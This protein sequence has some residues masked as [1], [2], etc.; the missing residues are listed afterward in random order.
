MHVMKRELGLL[1]VFDAVAQTGSVTAAANQ[2]SMSQPALSH[3]L[4]RLRDL[5]GDALFVRHGRGLVPTPRAR[6]MMGPVHDMLREAGALL[7]PAAFDPRT[8]TRCLRIGA[9]E[10]A[11][12]T[13]LPPLVRVLRRKAPAMQLELVSVGPETLQQLAQGTLDL[14]FWGTTA[15]G[16]QFRHLTLFRENYVG[17]AASTHPVFRTAASRVPLKGYLAYP[18][19]VVSLRDPGRSAVDEALRASGH[20]RR[21]GLSTPSFLANMAA[22]RG[23]DLLATLP[24]RLCQGEVMKGLRRFSLPVSVDPYDYGLIWHERSAGDAALSWICRL[25]TT[26][27]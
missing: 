2:L 17:V 7:K 8:D 27:R 19:A 6:A 23:S 13:L 21:I 25:A 18:H 22:L 1:V 11:A 5:L 16:G 10:Y 4:N 20:T 12:L 24:S 15:P 9:S 3:A 14:S 26:L